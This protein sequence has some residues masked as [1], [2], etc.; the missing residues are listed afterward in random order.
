MAGYGLAPSGPWFWA[1]IP[2]F[3]FMGLHGPSIQSLLT[4]RVGPSEQG[5]LQGIQG[6]LMGITGML[7]PP[8]F[9]AVF[10]TAIGRGASARLPGAPFLV[11]AAL[12]VVGV[13]AA[14]RATRL[15]PKGAP[16]AS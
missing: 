12:L 1:V 10:A 11:S 14:E 8:L 5:R 15:A 3:A 2:V 7:G 9:T 16:G 6:S 13:F 4:R